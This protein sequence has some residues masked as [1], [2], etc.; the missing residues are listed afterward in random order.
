MDP[1][2]NIC[3]KYDLKLIEDCAQSHGATYKNKFT[4]TFGDYGAFSFYPTKNLGAL[5]DAGAVLSNNTELAKNIIKLRNYGST[6]KYYNDIVGFNSR[7][8]EIQA[9]FL[10]VKLKRLDE[11]NNHKR[12]LIL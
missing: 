9:A 7:L 1:I 11:I 4:G 8:D 6:V 3:K 12:K 10:S 5:G 2:L